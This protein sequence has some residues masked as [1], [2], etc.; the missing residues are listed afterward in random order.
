MINL[1]WL[2]VTA[3][4]SAGKA[5]WSQ[6]LENPTEAEGPVISVEQL[7]K[8][9]DGPTRVSLRHENAN[10]DVV[11][12]DATRK[13][14]VPFGLSARIGARGPVTLDL[15]DAPLWT[16]WDALRQQVQVDRKGPAIAPRG[17]LLLTPVVIQSQQV[18][19]ENSLFQVRTLGLRQ[20]NKGWTMVVNLVVDPKIEISPSS[21]RIQLTE[22]V[23]DQGNNLL[24]HEVRTST[25]YST[26]ASVWYTSLSQIRQA[27]LG[28]RLLRLRGTISGNAILKRENWEVAVADLPAQKTIERDGNTE[29]LRMS[30]VRRDDDKDRYFVE[31]SREVKSL[32]NYRFWGATKLRANSLHNAA[33]IS[34]VRLEDATGSR[35]YLRKSDANANYEDETYRYEWTGRFDAKP[36]DRRADDVLPDGEPAKLIWPLPGEMHH[37]EMPFELKDVPI[38]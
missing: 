33:L 38:N 25:L 29:V 11:L 31:V 21:G 12:K 17:P 34:G 32:I 27:P 19:Y 7:E 23:D 28:K 5:A 26:M 8:L 30:E 37:F 2:F 14:G 10:L 1:K 24:A 35:F 15:K 13:L 3:F 9:V 36:E 18:T 22:A 16:V 4:L 20:N 6:P